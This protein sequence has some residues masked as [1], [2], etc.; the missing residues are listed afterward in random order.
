LQLNNSSLTSWCQHKFV[1]LQENF[2]ESLLVLFILETLQL[3]KL[4]LEVLFN[5]QGNFLAS[6]SVKDTK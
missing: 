4:F 2:F 3:D 5:P 6:M 1:K